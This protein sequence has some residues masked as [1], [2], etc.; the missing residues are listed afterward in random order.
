MWDKY[1]DTGANL[2]RHIRWFYVYLKMSILV[3][4]FSHK[5]HE[6]KQGLSPTTDILFLF[7]KKWMARITFLAVLH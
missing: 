3:K 6:F 1:N 7:S 5:S 2:V 4:T